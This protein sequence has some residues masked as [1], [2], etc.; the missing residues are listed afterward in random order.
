M[1]EDAGAHG[2]LK[3]PSLHNQVSTRNVFIS[4]HRNAVRTKDKITLD[5]STVSELKDARIGIAIDH[6]GA[7]VKHCGQAVAGAHCQTLELRMQIAPMAHNSLRRF[8]SRSYPKV[9][10]THRRAL[11]GIVAIAP[12]FAAYRIENNLLNGGCEEF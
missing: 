1:P 9:E 11:D 8:R 2:R 7:E 12:L 10:E 6:F 4:A 3:A 5:T